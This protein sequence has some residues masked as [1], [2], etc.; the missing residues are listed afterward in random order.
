MRNR[1]AARLAVSF[2]FLFALGILNAQL[3]TSTILGTVTDPSGAAVVAAQVTAIN[4]GTNFTRTVQ[5]NNRGEY[6]ME[7][8]PVGNYAVEITAQ[9]FKK[10]SQ[11]G[12]ALAVNVDDRVNAALQIGQS[13]EVVD[14]TADAPQVDTTDAQIGRTVDNAEISD[15]PIVNRNVYTLLTLTAGIDSSANSIVLGYPEQR[16]MINGGV[17]GGAGSVNYYL[18]GGT[19][20]TGLRNTGN[21]APNPDAVEEFRVITNNYDAEFGR[22][23]GGVV[24]ILT[25]SGTNQIHGSLF[26]FLRNTDLNANTWGATSKPPLHRNQFGGSVGGPIKKDKTFFFGTYSGLR[27]ITTTFVN[28]AVVPTAAERSG[29]FSGDAKLPVDPQLCPVSQ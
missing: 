13:T 9:G 12:I 29:N 25:K 16:T 26:E 18:D 3:T 28:S 10:F 24:N 5:T 8:M 23:A 20:M 15:L 1:V 7:F 6:R 17:D 4:A 2:A 11:T 22:F 21:I 14:V 27:Q 19:N